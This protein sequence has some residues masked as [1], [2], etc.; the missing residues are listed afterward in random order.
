MQQLHGLDELRNDQGIIRKFSAKNNTTIAISLFLSVSTL[1]FR[2]LRL[3]KIIERME[4]GK[5][6]LFGC[7]DGDQDILANP[8]FLIL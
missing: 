2:F 3:A 4:N 8:F 1:S 7:S 5:I 6:V